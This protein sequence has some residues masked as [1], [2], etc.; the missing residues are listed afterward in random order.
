MAGTPS[1]PLPIRAAAAELASELRRRYGDE[2]HVVSLFGSW[3]RGEADAESDV[4]VAVVLEHL[5]WARRREVIDLATDIGEPRD[6]R[7]SPTLFDRTTWERWREQ[8]RALVLDI[9]GEGVP[10]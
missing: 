2:V 5:P 3:V 7:L 1:L 9:L 4:D 10:L 8:E 6:L